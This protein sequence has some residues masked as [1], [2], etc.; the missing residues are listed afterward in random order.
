MQVLNTTDPSADFARL[1]V[2]VL[3]RVN[4]HGRSARHILALHVLEFKNRFVFI[5]QAGLVQ[6]RDS[7]VFLRTV[8]L[9]H[10]EE[11]VNLSDCRDVVRDEGL[12]L[13][14]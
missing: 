2:R 1:F 4:S 9:R 12:D 6:H 13:R 14:V 7:Q 5:V 10:L 11:G 3:D 8:W